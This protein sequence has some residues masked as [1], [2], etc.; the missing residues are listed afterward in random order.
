VVPR[1]L[2]TL[3]WP[4]APSLA[5]DML[6]NTILLAG[7]S[8]GWNCVSGTFMT[9]YMSAL[10]LRVRGVQKESRSGDGR[11]CCPPRAGHCWPLLVAV[12]RCPQATTSAARGSSSVC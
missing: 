6:L 12:A 8:C 11:L 3:W 7:T 4:D 10:A 2:R 9:V 5:V 1:S